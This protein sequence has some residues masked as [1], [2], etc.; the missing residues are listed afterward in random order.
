MPYTRKDNGR[1]SLE[2]RTIGSV[3]YI[4]QPATNVAVVKG[5]VVVAPTFTYKR[6]LY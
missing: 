1:A 5:D 6:R 4:S 2:K 3:G